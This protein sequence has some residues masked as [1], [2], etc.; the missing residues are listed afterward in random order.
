MSVLARACGHSRLSD[1]SAR[2]LSTFN[3]KMHRLTGIA[4][5][6]RHRLRTELSYDIITKGHGGSLTVESQAGEGTT[7]IIQLPYISK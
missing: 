7:F 1:F 6:R 4:H 2:D 5:R 3:H